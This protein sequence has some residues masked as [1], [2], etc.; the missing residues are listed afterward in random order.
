MRAAYL[1]VTATLLALT[2]TAL[3]NGGEPRPEPPG[4]MRLM[5]FDNAT[6]TSDCI[7]NPVT[8]L[9]AA[10]TRQACYLRHDTDLCA[11]VGE[12]V[13][14]HYDVSLENRRDAYA[15]YKIIEIEELTD[16]NIP[17]GMRRLSVHR[18]D[19]DVLWRPGDVKVLLQW[20][21]C[22]LQLGCGF[23]SLVPKTYLVRPAGDGWRVV[24]VDTPSY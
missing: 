19:P 17:A 10:E 18:S 23:W 7:G 15:H 14:F 2:T 16:A 4:V 3:A 11:V 24:T 5:T 6:S 22:D 8:P 21:F 13:T 1:A 12:D 9:C 20:Q